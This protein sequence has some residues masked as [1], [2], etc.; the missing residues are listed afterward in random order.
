M[1]VWF[2][3]VLLPIIAAGFLHNGALADTSG[4]I[5]L[6][7]LTAHATVTGLIDNSAFLPST[8]A[9]PAHRDFTG[10]IALGEVLMGTDPAL[11]T[12]TEVLGKNP[13]VFPAVTLAFYTAGGDLV[14]VDREVI[15]AG[16]TAA[17]TSY[18]DMIVQPGRVWSEPQDGEWS[19]AAF[20]FALVH[21]I[22]GESHNGVATFLYREGPSRT[23]VSKSS[24]RQHPTML[25]TIS[26]LGA[27]HP[28][29]LFPA[30]SKT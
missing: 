16:S 22:E 24:S 26:P 21:S 30:A 3:R 5:R 25:K 9:Q 4:Q 11:F 27:F 7:D 12:S 8:A 10:S 29:A 19:R 1:P 17:G 23:C 28:Q 18:W 6:A 15:R 20:P 2:V 13:Q 14:P